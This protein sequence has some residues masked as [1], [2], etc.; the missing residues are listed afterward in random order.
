MMK[1]ERNLTFTR[2]LLVGL[3]CLPTACSRNS[4]PQQIAN[5]TTEKPLKEASFMQ[6]QDTASEHSSPGKPTAPIELDYNFPEKAVVG[7]D[8]PVKLSIWVRAPVA[9]VVLHFSTTSGLQLMESNTEVSLALGPPRQP[10]KHQVT[11]QPNAEGLHYL[12]VMA[13]IDVEGAPQ[14]RAF[15][16]PVRVGDVNSKKIQSG[17]GGKV[18]EDATGQRIISLPASS[19]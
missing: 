17:G 2:L 7:A 8:L 6:S 1:M 10:V 18:M 11:V 19:P 5:E 15:S 12:N 14:A 13:A 4:G 9:D 3:L 16:I